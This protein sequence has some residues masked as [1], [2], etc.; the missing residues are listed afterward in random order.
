MTKRCAK[1]TRRNKKTGLCEEKTT[2]QKKRCPKGSRRNPKTKRCNK[3]T[4]VS[5]PVG[6][7]TPPRSNP[8]QN[9]TRK[10]CAKGTRR[11]KKTG[12][13]EEVKKN[14]IIEIESNTP[15]ELRTLQKSIKKIPT[16]VEDIDFDKPSSPPRSLIQHI[17]SFSPTLNKPLVRRED[18]IHKPIFG[19]ND[20]CDFF[21][22]MKRIYYLKGKVPQVFV[23]GIG[24]VPY[25]DTRAQEVLLYNLNAS[26]KSLNWKNIIAP[27][28]ALSNCWFNTFFMSFFISDKGRKFFKFLRYFMITGKNIRTGKQIIPIEN[29]K[30]KLFAAFN[31]CIEASI[32]GNPI[33]I[34]LD[35][36]LIIMAVHKFLN[37][38]LPQKGE[39]SNPLNYYSRMIQFL[40]MR[41]VL[42]HID[43]ELDD[44]IEI[45]MRKYIKTQNIIPN[46]LFLNRLNDYKGK[47]LLFIEVDGIRYELDSVISRDTHGQHFC[48]CLKVNNKQ[49]VFDGVSYSKLSEFEWE[50]LINTNKRWTIKGSNWTGTNNPIKWNFMKNYHIFIYYRVK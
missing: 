16:K 43:E 9:K 21:D 17:K 46:V 31:M 2:T 6:K 41:N 24:C 50:K 37:K 29:N 47:N 10:R 5:L 45:N 11:N 30:M 14:N 36:N 8:Q 7:T 13:C 4:N 20:Q 22:K 40:G 28:Q 35:T 38:S 48:C 34:D 42:S 39:R 18:S 25:T 33:I 12:L 26:D 44:N 15:K 32:T 49:L 19:V 3:K 23:E 1:G 27:K